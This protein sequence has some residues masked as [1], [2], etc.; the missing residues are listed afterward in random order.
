MSAGMACPPRAWWWRD[1][2][3]S[4]TYRVYDRTRRELHIEK[5]LDVIDFS[6]SPGLLT[7]S[8]VQS[9]SSSMWLLPKAQAV[10][11]ECSFNL[12]TAITE[13]VA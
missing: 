7:I 8:P 3:N 2:Q 10:D 6:L 4:D 13:P 12:L 9:I 1:Q 11:L 5:A